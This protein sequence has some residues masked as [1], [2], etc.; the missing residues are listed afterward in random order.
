MLSRRSSGAVPVLFR[1]PVGVRLAAACLT[2][3]PL[4]AE[5]S[6]ALHQQQDQRR[7]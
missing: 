2:L 4:V 5:H 1:S 6:S 3:P 7:H